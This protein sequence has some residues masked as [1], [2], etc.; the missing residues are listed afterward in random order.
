MKA[1]KMTIALAFAALSTTVSANVPLEEEG[2]GSG[3]ICCH[4]KY[5]IGNTHYYECHYAPW[6][7]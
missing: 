3:G 5:S 1:L 6:L 2:G 7:S 4:Y